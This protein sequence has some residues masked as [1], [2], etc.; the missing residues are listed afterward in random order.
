[1]N[2]QRY[3]FTPTVGQ[4]VYLEATANAHRQWDGNAIV[5]EVTDIGK[6][7]FYV[8]VP[9]R[10]NQMRFRLA[11][12]Q[13]RDEANYN[14]IAYASKRDFDEAQHGKLLQEFLAESLPKIG[15]GKALSYAALAQIHDIL[16]AA[17]V[18]DTVP[19]LEG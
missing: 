4:T 10:G 14:Y 16:V 8:R 1:M 15:Y 17:G 12:C 5:G 11:N 18:P 7:Y 6:L 13:S 3:V 9:K 2:N 19:P